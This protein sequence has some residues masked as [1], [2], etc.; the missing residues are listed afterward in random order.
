MKEFEAEFARYCGVKECVALDSG[1]AALHLAFEG[2]GIGPGDEVIVPTN[3]FIA[4]AAA[5]VM[6]GA[7]VVLADSDPAATELA[8]SRALRMP[9]YRTVSSMVAWCIGGVVFIIASWSVAKYAAPVVAVATA[10]GATATSII[11]YL[12]S[13][14]VLRPV[15]LILSL[16]RPRRLR[17]PSRRG[18]HRR[19]VCHRSRSLTSRP[20]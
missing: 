9:F 1:T 4:S 8:R 6:A 13:E 14:R 17:Q 16:R 12:Q 5:V 19:M 2:L 11:G 7:T 15:V 3:T 10:L 18:R 20:F